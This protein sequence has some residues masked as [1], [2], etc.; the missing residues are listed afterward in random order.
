LGFAGIALPFVAA[1]ALAGFA[2]GRFAAGA[3]L[4]VAAGLRLPA[5]FVAGL[6]AGDL[7]FV[8]GGDLRA[9]FT[10]FFAMIILVR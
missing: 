7:P 2:A 9:G 8:P 5:L 6:R 4:L 3:R 1:F 10:C